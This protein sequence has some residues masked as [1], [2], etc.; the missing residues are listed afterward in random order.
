MK[1]WIAKNSEVPVRD[2]LVTQVTAAIAA[3]DLTGGEK[4]PSTRS[5]ARQYS[6]HPN[7]V[8]AAFQKLVSEG[9]LEFRRGS[10]FYVASGADD[11]LAGTRRLDRSID[12]LFAVGKGLG[13]S[14]SDILKRVRRRSVGVG[15]PSLVLIEP[16]PDLRAILVKELETLFPEVEGASYENLE[17]AKLPKRS[18]LVALQDERPK[19]EPHLPPDT[20]CFYLKVSSPA[21]AMSLEGPLSDGATIGVASGWEDFLSFGRVMLLA[22]GIA[23]GS[24]VVRSTRDAEWKNAVATSSVVICDSLTAASLDG[25]PNVRVFRLISDDSVTA[26]GKLV[27]RSSDND[28]SEG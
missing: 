16:N 20:S 6:V 17:D 26:I 21:A 13:L 24:L 22:A 25:N 27:R 3:G 12:E 10:G 15:K 7:T 14:R 28:T 19:I 9:L 23:P 5:I 8:S 2:Q 1:L 4:L 18:L 11:V